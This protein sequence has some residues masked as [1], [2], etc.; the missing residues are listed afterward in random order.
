MSKIY[1]VFVKDGYKFDNGFG[2]FLFDDLC[3]STLTEAIDYAVEHEYP[4][5]VV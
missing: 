2:R 5:E 3:F 1:I 4:Y